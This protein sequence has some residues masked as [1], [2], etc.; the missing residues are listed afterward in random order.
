MTGI[1]IREMVPADFDEVARIG[2]KF[3]NEIVIGKLS[4][5]QVFAVI[6]AC[7]KTG[8][9]LIAEKE[10]K[11]VGIIAGHCIDYMSIGKTFDEVIWYVEEKN[12]GIGL[13]L[14]KRMIN[15]CKIKGCKGVFMTAYNNKHFYSV[16]KIYKKYE[17]NEAE[18]KYYKKL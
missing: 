12:R 7:F 10:E 2:R 13:I 15:L 1:V 17:F 8:L 11:I 9:V 5:E 18:R 3:A 14:F 6:N 16:E 4:D